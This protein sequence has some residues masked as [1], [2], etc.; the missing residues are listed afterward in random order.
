MEGIDVTNTCNKCKSVMYCNA[1]CKKK[2]R[3]KH[4]I[5]CEEH[6]RLAA[7]RAAELHDEKLFK[8]P[9]PLEDCLIC[10]QR[11]PYL[12]TGSRY[13]E[14]CGKVICT[15]CMYAPVY[16][17]EGNVV[18]G[19]TCPFCRTPHPETEKEVVK[20]IEKRVEDGDAMAIYNL[21]TY[22]LRGMNGYPQ[23][24]DKSIELCHRAAELG[25]SKA[26]FDIGCYYDLDRGL[27]R[28]AKHYWELAAIGGNVD[29]RHNLGAIEERSGN[30]KRGL[31][32]FMIAVED[33]GN[34]SLETIQKMHKIGSATKDDYTKA[35][36]SYQEYLNEIK[37]DQ[38]DKVAA[39]DGHCK[40]Y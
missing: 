7:E 22:Y 14:C 15:G 35:L 5:K 27:E 39:A 31:R 21:G 25:I 18:T 26:Y 28:E 30:M 29:A 32:H 11:M 36:K 4:K 8:Q 24:I 40:Y 3:H 1:A 16:D 38:R 23:D 19:K 9:P 37:S 33:G 20:R 2:H 12:I 17:N 6:L 13:C 10:M 34:D